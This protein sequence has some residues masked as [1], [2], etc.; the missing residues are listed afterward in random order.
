MLGQINPKLRK[1]PWILRG[2]HR[3]QL[4]PKLMK[5]SLQRAGLVVQNYIEQRAMDLQTAVVV[6]ES[7]FPEPVHEEAHPRAGRA[8]HLG[9]SFLTDLGDNGFRNALLAEMSQQQQ[10][11]GES[12]FTGVEEL[13]N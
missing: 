9:Q 11:P 2:C 10:N 4:N 12:L 6:N 13:V 3:T 5:A 8:D 1:Q 7:Q